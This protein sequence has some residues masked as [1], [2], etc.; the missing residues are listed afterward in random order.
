MQIY[1]FVCVCV[2]VR[3]SQVQILECEFN[4]DGVKRLK[5]KIPNTITQKIKHWNLSFKFLSF[6]F[7]CTK[8]AF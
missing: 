4:V 2:C 7:V 6:S 3:T 8:Y 1:A 5:K